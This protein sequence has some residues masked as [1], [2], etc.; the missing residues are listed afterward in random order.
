MYKR[1]VIIALSF[2]AALGG[3]LVILTLFAHSNQLNLHTVCVQQIEPVK[4]ALRQIIA[5]SQ[6]QLPRLSYYRQHRRELAAAE[7]DI[8]HELYVFR[9]GTCP[10]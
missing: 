4:T 8:G 5:R 3:L 2:G 7:R 9:E 1:T 6:H 10:P